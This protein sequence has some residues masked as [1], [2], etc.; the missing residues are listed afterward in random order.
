MFNSVAVGD[1]DLREVGAGGMSTT[2]GVH[3][4]H[5]G[6][7][8]PSGFT[9]TVIP[10]EMTRRGGVKGW[11]SIHLMWLASNLEPSCLVGS[12]DTQTNMQATLY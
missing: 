5:Q 11:L 1:F 8:P 9:S 2:V 10:V 4:Y 7:R 3:V 12:Y 6:S